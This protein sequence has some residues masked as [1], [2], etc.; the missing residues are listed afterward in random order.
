MPLSAASD[1]HPTYGKKDVLKQIRDIIRETMMPSWFGSVPGNFSDISVGTIKADEWHSLITVYIPI[2]LISLWGGPSSKATLKPILDHTM[3]LVSAVYISCARTMT[4]EC[5]TA[6][7]SYIASYV[8]S[9]KCVHPA[10][11]VQPNHHATFHVYDYLV[12]FSPVHS[13]WTFPF[14]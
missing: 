14:E 11:N 1:E 6:Y 3:D 13:W 9:L 5:A 12:L 2:T 7:H 8:G 4:S 10:F